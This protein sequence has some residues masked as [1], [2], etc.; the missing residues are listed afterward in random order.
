V[1]GGTPACAVCCMVRLL[2]VWLVRAAVPL[3]VQRVHCC[4]CWCG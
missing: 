2:L 1:I 3:H 4:S